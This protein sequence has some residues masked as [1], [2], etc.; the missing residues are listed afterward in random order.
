MRNPIPRSTFLV[1]LI[2]G[3]APAARDTT[4]DE[5][6]IR[7]QTERLVVAMQ[8]ADP[9]SAAALFTEDGTLFPANGTPVVGNPAVRN[10]AVQTFAA[11]RVVDAQVTTDEVRVANG[12]AVSQG[13]WVMKVAIGEIEAVDTNRWMVVWERQPDG[14]WKIDRDIWNS[15]RPLP[16]ASPAR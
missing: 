6:A 12:W 2:L 1:L 3:C 4:A 7:A 13:T 11:M 8:A 16:A 14:G 10:W 15:I 5:A 9:D